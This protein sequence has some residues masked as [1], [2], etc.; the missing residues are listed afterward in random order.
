V[1][2]R[3]LVH[4]GT[5]SESLLTGMLGLRPAPTQIEAFVYLVYAVPMALFVLWPRRGPVRRRSVEQ[6]TVG[7]AQTPA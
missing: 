3:W 2:L 6:P 4:P 5:V 1:S 7:A